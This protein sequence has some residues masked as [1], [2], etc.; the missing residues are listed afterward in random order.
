MKSLKITSAPSSTPNSASASFTSSG[1]RLRNNCVFIDFFA[2]VLAT[3]DKKYEG[4]EGPGMPVGKV[5]QVIDGDT[6]VLAGGE[7]VRIAGLDTPELGKRGGQAAKR[8][9]QQVLS[10]RRRVGLSKPLAKSYGRT[11]R[12]VTVK[13]K[14]VNNLVSKPLKRR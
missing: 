9:L 2:K 11:V 6:F 7:R 10:K 14:P 3:E 5:K 4:K 8:R 13:G 12:R 1:K